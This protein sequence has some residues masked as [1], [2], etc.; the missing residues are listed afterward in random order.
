MGV[1]VVVTATPREFLLGLIAASSR[2]HGLRWKAFGFPCGLVYTATLRS[3]RGRLRDG[4]GKATIVALG[5]NPDG[6]AVDLWL[7]D[8]R[9]KPR[10]ATYALPLDDCGALP[11]LLART[12]QEAAMR[13]AVVPLSEEVGE[14]ATLALEAVLGMSPC[15]L[16]RE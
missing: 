6:E 11:Q 9:K 7:R 10:W 4:P 5:V 2:P 15:E 14:A 16:D 12:A 3:E 1:V 8:A 13:P